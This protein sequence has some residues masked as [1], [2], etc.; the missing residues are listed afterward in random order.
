[1]KLSYS[2]ALSCVIG[3]LALATLAAADAAAESEDSSLLDKASSLFGLSSTESDHDAEKANEEDKLLQ[4]LQSNIA[5]LQQ[6]NKEL[7]KVVYHLLQQQKESPTGSQDQDGS[8]AN[9]NLDAEGSSKNTEMSGHIERFERHMA[10]SDGEASGE[11]A[12]L[13]F[14]GK[15]TTIRMGQGDGNS[16]IS[17]TK[18]QLNVK[19]DNVNLRSSSVNIEGKSSFTARIG[20]S[21]LGLS[22]ESAELSQADSRLS[23]HESDTST[24]NFDGTIQSGRGILGFGSDEKAGV[25]MSAGET[26]SMSFGEVDDAEEFHGLQF[27]DHQSDSTLSLGGEVNSSV[28][29]RAGD[30]HLRL[31]ELRKDGADDDNIEN[32]LSFMMQSGQSMIG[33][34]ESLQCDHSDD[35]EQDKFVGILLDAG[36]NG[37]VMMSSGY[38]SFF[39]SSGDFGNNSDCAD[40]APHDVVL[41]AGDGDKEDGEPEPGAFH[42]VSGNAS[43]SFAESVCEDQYADAKCDELEYTNGGTVRAGEG[44]D[45][46]L[47]G[48]DWDGEQS[49]S[50]HVNPGRDERKHAT[51]N[52]HIGG[53]EGFSAIYTGTVNITFTADDIAEPR[54]WAAN[55]SL[56]DYETCGIA[57]YTNCSKFDIMYVSTRNAAMSA[58]IIDEEFCLAYVRAMPFDEVQWKCRDEDGNDFCDETDE[59]VEPFVN[60]LIIQ[61]RNAVKADPSETCSDDVLP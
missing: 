60:F 41:T 4:D 3:V 26:S 36:A 57:G 45:L 23:L 18:E 27:A 7:R 13:W 51:G 28:R 38:S 2:L 19:S 56:Y 5:R 40:I 25:H 39:M 35:A 37:T 8:A 61:R 12:L 33:F 47:S 16:T 15:E 53:G 46:Y 42:F 59:H 43:V 21:K 22:G 58:H 29:F 44:Q 10:E 49:G 9:R 54:H 1:M 30:A 11:Y 6:D 55:V 14:K 32:Y 34:G 17:G 20:N 50:I 31:S 52:I 48:G 24:D